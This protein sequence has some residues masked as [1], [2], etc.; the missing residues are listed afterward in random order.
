MTKNKRLWQSTSS[1][2][3][4]FSTALRSMSERDK[5]LLRVQV[6]KQMELPEQRERILEN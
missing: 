4:A 5:A 1:I 6:R 3:K 2:A